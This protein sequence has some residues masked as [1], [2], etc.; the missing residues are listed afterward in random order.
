MGRVNWRVISSLR[1]APLRSARWLAPALLVW[2]LAGAGSV[3]ATTP[4]GLRG[5]IQAAP[6]CPVES[7]P[8][9]PRC[10]PRPLRAALRIA[11]T[12]NPTAYVVV[13]SNKRGRF[14]VELAPGR[15]VVHPRRIHGS[16]FPVPPGPFRVTIHPQHFTYRTITYDTGI[17]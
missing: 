16:D 13:H 11:P 7:V 2:A 15:Y 14:D 9:Q 3:A 8:P 6:T 4:S 12:D 5:R 10:A 17:R 1:T